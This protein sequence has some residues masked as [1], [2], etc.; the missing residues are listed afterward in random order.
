MIMVAIIAFARVFLLSSKKVGPDQLVRLLSERSVDQVR[1]RLNADLSTMSAAEIR[2]YIRARALGVLRCQARLVAA[3]AGQ[4]ALPDEV[5]M[6][7]LERTVHLVVRQWMT[8]H[9]APVSV[10]VG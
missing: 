4:P 7:A 1:D 3:D 5:V 9:A 6:L 2:G 8:T 10:R